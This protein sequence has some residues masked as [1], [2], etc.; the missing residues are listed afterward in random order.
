MGTVL[1]VIEDNSK[2]IKKNTGTFQI[3]KYGKC[4]RKIKLT[5]WCKIIGT[6]QKQRNQLAFAMQM[7]NYLHK[8]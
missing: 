3:S 7:R 1:I 8:N 4:G 2:S 5:D 6:I